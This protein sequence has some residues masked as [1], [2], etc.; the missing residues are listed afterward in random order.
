[1]AMCEV[2]GK[3]VAFGNKVSH[4]NKKSRRTWKPNVKKIK[5]LLQNGQRKRIYVCTSCI[6]AG[7]VVRA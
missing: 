7:K 5:V 2:C 4:S 1:M 6:K 3:K